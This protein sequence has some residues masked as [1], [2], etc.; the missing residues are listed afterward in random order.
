M[1]RPHQCPLELHFVKIVGGREFRGKDEGRVGS[2]GE[3]LEDRK[4]EV[5]GGNED[6]VERKQRI[7]PPTPRASDEGGMKGKLLRGDDEQMK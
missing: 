2:I 5:N 3:M 1:S 6:E 4:S 7:S